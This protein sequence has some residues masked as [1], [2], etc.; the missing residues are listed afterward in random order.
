[1]RLRCR[2]RRPGTCS[3]R[4]VSCSP[5]VPTADF[6]RGAYSVVPC[7]GTRTIDEGDELDLGD[8]TFEVLHLPG[9]SPGSIGLWEEETGVLFYGDA[10][11]DGPLFDENANSTSRRI[12]PRCAGS[13]CCPST[14]STV[15]TASFGRA[16]LVELCS[17]YL[18]DALVQQPRQPPM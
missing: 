9:H 4:T 2:S 3:P 18:T 6:D 14:S 5:P 12:A 17:A 1:M 8:R 13:R 16:R 11:Y 10:V 7:T 15:V